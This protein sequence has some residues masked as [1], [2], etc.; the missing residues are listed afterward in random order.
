V[1]RFANTQFLMA[2]M[3]I[4][5]AWVYLFVIVLNQYDYRDAF[6][7]LVSVKSNMNSAKG[8]Q[9]NQKHFHDGNFYM[10]IEY[11]GAAL[12]SLADFALGILYNS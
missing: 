10:N 1:P 8:S 5:I 12:N 9:L 11:Y 2:V 4:I 7:P 3:M 6:F